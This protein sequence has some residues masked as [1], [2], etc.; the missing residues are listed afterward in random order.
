MNP[1]Q[2]PPASSQQALQQLLAQAL[3]LHQSGQFEPAKSLYR[4]ILSQDKRQVDV[5][6]LLGVLSAQTGAL[7][8]AERLLSKA[9][10]LRPAFPDA[11]YNLGAIH[12]QKKRPAK[13][14][15]AFKNCLAHQPQHAGALWNLAS[16]QLDL[17]RY[18]EAE[19][20][21]RAFL[22]LQPGNLDALHSLA[23]T[24]SALR[25]YGEAKEIVLSLLAR[26][27]TA[28]EHALLGHILFIES[29]YDKAETHLQAALA[30]ISDLLETK[31]TYSGLLRRLGRLDQALILAEE[32]VRDH[33]RDAT[34][35][36]NRSL[37]LKDLGRYDEAISEAD[38][39]F[40]LDSK[41][42]DLRR[43]RA[44]LLLQA[45]RLEEGWRENEARFHAIV[46]ATKSMSFPF[47]KLQNL[48]ELNHHT[49]LVWPEQGIGD[50][51]TYA[52]ALPDLIARAKSVEILAAPKLA[53]LF[54]RSFPKARIILNS[55]ESQ[56]DRHLPMGD[57]FGL[58]RPSIGSFP[59]QPFLQANTAAALAWRKRLD[60]AGPGLKVGIG[61]RST[62][63]N[64][65]RELHFFPSL[66]PLGPILSQPGVTFIVTQ[67]KA[68]QAQIEEASQA[69]GCK[70]VHFD[71]LDL[72]DDLDNSAAMMSGLDLVISNGSTNAFLAAA[73]GVPVW[74]FFLADYHWDCLGGETIPWLA[75]LTPVERLWQEG[76]DNAVRRIADA[77]HASVAQGRLMSPVKRSPLR[78]QP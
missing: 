13:A 26:H 45:G 34:V 75:S 53:P 37:C 2:T 47:P 78:L 4:R 5:L 60:E 54:A 9:V 57:L 17:G 56:A 67:P 59:K 12:L 76:W 30:E 19:S 36:M 15:D 48:A 65:N 55:S 6:F 18:G 46:D 63:V 77:L 61:W 39:A 32:L 38:A 27:P 11:L 20:S 21:F 33:P 42:P 24:L 68:D 40:A 50:N 69:F 3:Q 62:L 72:F 1:T 49:V 51:V 25:R 58:F 10:E 73:L 8:E 64:K 71:D 35:R 22:R 74:M 23:L 44:Q 16:L 52:S 28:K 31:T 43:S 70:M 7:G 29:D 14:E 41:N 66:M